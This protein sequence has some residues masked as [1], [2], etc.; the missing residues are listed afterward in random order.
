MIDIP[1]I[2]D[3][4]ILTKR[5]IK[6]QGCRRRILLQRELMLYSPDLIKCLALV[7]LKSKLDVHLILTLQPLDQPLAELLR[8]ASRSHKI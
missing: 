5:I 1:D 3:I 2:P 7:D 8:D 4:P 6:H